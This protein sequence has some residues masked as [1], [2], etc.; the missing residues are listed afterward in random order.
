MNYPDDVKKIREFLE[1]FDIKMPNRAICILYE[2]FC[3]EEYF[4]GWLIID[5]D[6]LYEFVEWLDLYEE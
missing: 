3:Q 5:E 4:A 1:S 2:E 6:T